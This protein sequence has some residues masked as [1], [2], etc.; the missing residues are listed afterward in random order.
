MTELS[1]KARE[2]LRQELRN[3]PIW[4]VGRLQLIDFA[5]E[6]VRDMIKS[7]PSEHNV[8]NLHCLVNVF[9]KHVFDET[10]AISLLI[11]RSIEEEEERICMVPAVESSIESLESEILRD[12]GTC[13]VC[14]ED[15]LCGCEGLFMPCSHVFHGDCINK[16][17][18]T[19]HYC[20][21][22]RFEMPTSQ[23]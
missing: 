9:H 6:K 21:I 22:C 19:S 16:W 2:T 1:E 4:S 3:W 18:R 15:I 7:M 11:Q 10:R 5:L 17:L 12:S 23:L 14:L 13:C 8:V 20:P